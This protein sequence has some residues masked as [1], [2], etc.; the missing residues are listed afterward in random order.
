MPTK[1]FS[2]EIPFVGQQNQKAAVCSTISHDQY[3]RIPT[4]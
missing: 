1:I 3:R 2:F 4:T